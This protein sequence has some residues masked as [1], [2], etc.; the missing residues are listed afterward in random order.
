MSNMSKRQCKLVG[1]TAYENTLFAL[2]FLFSILV[3]SPA[4]ATI[5][6]TVT[7]TGTPL[8]GPVDSVVA[9]DSESVDVQDAAPQLSLVK[10]ANLNDEINADGLAE[11][12]ETTTY[13]YTVTN[14][15]NVTLVNIAIQDTHEGVLLSPAPSGETIVLEGP[16]QPSDIGTPNDGL[17]NLLDVGA[18]AT[19]TITLTVTQE[20]VDNQ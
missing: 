2:V 13:T 7:V 18:V 3:Q 15:G 1:R 10:S 11:A 9:T 19:F 6:N 12:G 8:G 20:E 4:F 16:N 14:S 17:I 5:D